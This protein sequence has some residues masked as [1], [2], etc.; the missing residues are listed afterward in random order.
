M[1][2]DG[3]CL[4]GMGSQMVYCFPK[5]NFMFVCQGD[6]QSSA[7]FSS[8]ML[9]HLVKDYF[10]DEIE[11]TAL[12]ENQADYNALTSRLDDLTVDIPIGKDHADFEKEIDGVAYN[13]QDNPLG[14]KNFRFD[15]NERGGVL[16]YENARGEKQ[17]AFGR[18]KHED[19]AFPETDY[20]DKKVGE[21]SGR[22]LRALSTASWVN[23]K[24]LLLRINFIDIN[25]GNIYINFGFK[26]NEV[27]IC[28]MK[29]AEFFAW[30]YEG[31]AGGSKADK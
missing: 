8:R 27:G 19:I 31:Y 13:L 1:H 28:A 21:P 26:G 7:D 17:V 24:Q 9:L 5:K 2:D 16:T 12:T 6:T 22:G 15:F 18:N 25:L 4:S 10:Y 30:D 3:F 20:Y 14:W 23:D 29:R 11:D